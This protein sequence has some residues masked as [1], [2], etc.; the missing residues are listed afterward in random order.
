MQ[1]L[2]RLT[3]EERRTLYKLRDLIIRFSSDELKVFSYV[4]DNISVGEIIFER[5]LSQI[6]GVPK[7]ILVAM[8]LRDKGVI[9]R[10]EGCYNLARWLRPLRKKVGNFQ[11]LRLLLDR[12]P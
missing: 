6:H 11:D 9:E 2:T 12:L 5:D 8:S 10:G 4:W 1:S 3:E 7:P